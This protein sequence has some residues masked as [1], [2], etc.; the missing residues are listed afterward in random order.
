[1]SKI[2]KMTLRS[3]YI[4]YNLVEFIAYSTVRNYVFK[5][6]KELE[7]NN[8]IKRENKKRIRNTY[9]ILNPVR[10]RNKIMNHFHDEEL[11]TIN[12]GL[13]FLN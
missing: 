13:F 1:M 4:D 10:L 11:Y 8:L 9:I 2:D 12:E 3:F 7:Q 5:N 6:I